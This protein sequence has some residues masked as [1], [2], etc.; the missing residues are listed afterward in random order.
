[1]LSGSTY[2]SQNGVFRIRLVLWAQFPQ[3]P[4]RIPAEDLR[5][6]VH[7]EL[8]EVLEHDLPS[9]EPLERVVNRKV[10]AEEDLRGAD[11][12]GQDVAQVLFGW[13]GR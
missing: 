3:N 5:L 2:P 10:G 6:V 8:G 12:G 11:A 7:R 9:V 4:L 1:M 13:V